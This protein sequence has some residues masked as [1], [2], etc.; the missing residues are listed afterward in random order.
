MKNSS[1]IVVL[2]LLGIALLVGLAFLL[3][4]KKH[5]W[6]ETYRKDSKEPYGTSLVSQLLE[7]RFGKNLFITAFSRTSQS[8]AKSDS[9]R[10][11]N[12]IFL[13][14]RIYLNDEDA[15]T[16]LSFV[17]K[18]NNAFLAIQNIPAE[19]DSALGFRKCDGADRVNFENDSVCHMNFYHPAIASTKPYTFNFIFKGQLANYEWNNFSFSKDCDSLP[20]YERLG[21]SSPAH[22]NFI[23]IGYGKGW[24]YFHLNPLAFTNLQLLDENRVEYCERVFS[25]LPAGKTCWDEHSR[26][27]SRSRN[28]NGSHK[29]GPLSYIL[30]QLP[31]RWAWYTLLMLVVIYFLFHVVRRQRIIP[32]ILSPENTSLEFVQTVGELYYQQ[33]DHQKLCMQQMK[34]FLQFI[35]SRYYMQTNVIDE[36][37]VRNLSVKSEIKYE[38]VEKIF[39]L[40][41]A[42]QNTVVAV[43]ED[44]LIAYY[45][46]LDF[47]YRNCR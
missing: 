17:A 25:H 19:L 39:S 42:Y 38:Q 31:L 43:D 35:R 12:Y 45:K 11:S 41:R 15:D 28:E 10:I 36:S 2:V 21:Y 18:G 26:V 7:N 13:G 5:D 34:L 29:K 47:F 33:N 22:L 8:L 14:D 6:T 3:M 24:F 4:P 16:L 37:F 30:S 9:S 27:Y 20:A 40:F 32:V 44:E 46:T 1:K 23:R